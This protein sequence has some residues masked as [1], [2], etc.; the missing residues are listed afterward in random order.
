MNPTTQLDKS[1]LFSATTVQVKLT[2]RRSESYAL[3]QS[4]GTACCAAHIA[5]FPL[6]SQFT[7]I[8]LTCKSKEKR[9]GSLLRAK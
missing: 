1:D 9:C 8:T 2:D 3:S 4:T 7:S 5:S 6:P